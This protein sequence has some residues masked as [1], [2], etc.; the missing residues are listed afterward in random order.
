MW[1]CNFTTIYTNFN[2]TMETIR[3]NNEDNVSEVILVNHII[4]LSKNWDEDLT[5]I[6]LSNGEKLISKDSINTLEARINLST[7]N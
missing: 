2:Y 5:Y 7:N 4:R 1:T 3:F 6:H